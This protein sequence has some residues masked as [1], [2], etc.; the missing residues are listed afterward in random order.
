MAID[1]IDGTVI[2]DTDMIRCDPDDLSIFI[3]GLVNT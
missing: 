2:C 3:M 1:C